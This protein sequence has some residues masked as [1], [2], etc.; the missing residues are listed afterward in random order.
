MVNKDM[1]VINIGGRR[2]R[3]RYSMSDT[4]MSLVSAMFSLA[5]ASVALG[6][7]AKA[8]SESGIGKEGSNDLRVH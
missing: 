3:V 7:C 5:I 4:L 8:L 1:Q 6:V 2:A